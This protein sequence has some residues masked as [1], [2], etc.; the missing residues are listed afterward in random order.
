MP[1]AC[2]AYD[3]GNST[4]RQ[5]PSDLERFPL[6][7][8]RNGHRGI[9]SGAQIRFGLL[10]RQ[11]RGRAWRRDTRRT[12]GCARW[13]LSRRARAH[14]RRRACSPLGFDGDPL[15]GT[16]DGDGQRRCQARDRPQPLAKLVAVI[17]IDEARAR[18]VAEE[19]GAEHARDYHSLVGRVDAASVTVPTPRH[20]EIASDLIKSGIDVLVEKPITDTL[21]NAN[22]LA[23]LVDHSH[24]AS[25]MQ[26]VR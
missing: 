1:C 25:P 26:A 24:F 14:G 20:F 16:L 5:R 10:R 13:R 19:F 9:P 7:V 12:S 23:A 15:D 17:D 22:A 6:D 2:S 4:H 18:V 3:A 11:W 8:N 21:T